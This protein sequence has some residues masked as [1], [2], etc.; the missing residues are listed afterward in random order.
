MIDSFVET[1]RSKGAWGRDACNRVRMMHGHSKK[2]GHEK[3]EQISISKH[4]KNGEDGLRET[5]QQIG[6]DQRGGTDGYFHVLSAAYTVYLNRL[7]RVRRGDMIHVH[8]DWEDVCRQSSATCLL[9]RAPSG[10]STEPRVM[11][12]M[13]HVTSTAASSS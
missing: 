13:I 11:Q 2:V 12:S 8:A 10:V 4:V 7:L 3:S 1:L 5:A 6:V 9:I